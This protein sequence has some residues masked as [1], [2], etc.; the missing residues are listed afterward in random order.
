MKK[1]YLKYIYALSAVSLISITSCN[2]L[3]DFGDINTSP[4]NPSTPQ[5]NLLLS[6]AESYLASNHSG[7][8]PI[9]NDMA[10]RLYSQALSET[11]Y[12]SESRYATTHYDFNTIYT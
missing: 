3:K 12:T 8:Q 6:D 7:Y 5:A 11:L 2:K 9:I 1:S 10:P 4:N